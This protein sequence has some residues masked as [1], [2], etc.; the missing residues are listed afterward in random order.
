[1]I[2][3]NYVGVRFESF[4]PTVFMEKNLRIIELYDVYGELLTERQRQIVEM[5]FN[6][7]LSLGEIA[8]ELSISR[9]SVRDSLL[10]SEKI[11]TNFEEKLKV[12]KMREGFYKLSEELNERNETKTVAKAIID[13]LED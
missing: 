6:D 1:M 5:S 2:S 11:L 10:S 4:T 13:L 12:V 3:V 7:D 9:Q 8:D